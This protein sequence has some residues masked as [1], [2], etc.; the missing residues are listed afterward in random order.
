MR[1]FSGDA[2]DRLANVVGR[3]EDLSRL[4]YFVR[5]SEEM[6]DYEKCAL[7]AIEQVLRDCIAVAELRPMG[8][9]A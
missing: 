4:I 9:V 2:R 8:E 3:L 1:E 6:H 7:S 5:T